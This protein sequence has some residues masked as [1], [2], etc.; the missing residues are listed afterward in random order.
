MRFTQRSYALTL[1]AG[2]AMASPATCGY[3]DGEAGDP[4]VDEEILLNEIEAAATA[5]KL[6]I[7]GSAV[8]ASANDG[9]VPAN[10]VDGSLTT[11]WAANGDGQ[12]IRY[13]LGTTRTVSHIRVA[14]YN[15][16]NRAFAFDI[17]RSSDGSSWTK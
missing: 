12:W 11:R 14:P 13:D 2:F 1:L 8:T 7:P 6:T 5:T 16:A 4:S 15:G 10:T 9:N 17:Q 3:V